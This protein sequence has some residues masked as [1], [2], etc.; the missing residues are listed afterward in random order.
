M[1]EIKKRILHGAEDKGKFG[2]E[3]VRGNQ[4]LRRSLLQEYRLLGGSTRSHG[5]F[6]RRGPGDR[7]VVDGCVQIAE[8][9]SRTRLRG[10][11]KSFIST[12]RLLGGP[13]VNQPSS[14]LIQRR[15]LGKSKHRKDCIIID[16]RR[17]KSGGPPLPARPSA[18]PSMQACALSGC[19]L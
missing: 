10:N 4:R 2:L 6:G 1:A 18:A 8:M 9:Y 17:C 15:C 3:A 14:R 7:L 13:A 19:P 11:A 12:G 16:G 5:V